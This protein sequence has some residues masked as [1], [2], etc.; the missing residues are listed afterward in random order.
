MLNV[1][2]G[3]AAPETGQAYAR[4]RELWEQLGSPV[5][6]IEVPCGQS[7]YHAHRGELDRAQSLAEDLL[8]L[9]RRRNDSAG[10]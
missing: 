9:S 3:S 4:A 1:V 7:R 2:K 5:E 6:F 8:H 10:S